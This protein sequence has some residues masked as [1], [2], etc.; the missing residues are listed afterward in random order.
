MA[1]K[2]LVKKQIE[3]YLSDLNLK[4]DDFFYEKIST[5]KDGWIDI[6][7]FLNCNKVK[8]LKAKASDIADACVD[9]EKV[10]IS[11]DQKQ[12]R[13]KNNLALPDKQAKTEKKRD[14]KAADKE[15]KKEESAV[16]V[17]KE[18][19][20]AELNE[21]G[22]Y[23]LMQQDFENPIIVHFETD[24]KE[25]GYKV[26]WKDVENAIKGKF[27]K[28]KTVYSRADEVM[29]ELAFSNFHLCHEELEALEKTTL[30]V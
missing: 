23:V 17:K 10:E 20:D 9:S 29:G 24:A 16:K 8:E 30:T 19:E 27:K 5:S 6:S 4:K 2:A 25:E 12:I 3:Y 1:Q 21:K 13:R 14:A 22:N 11:K 26:N 28:L 7:L 15:E 18:V